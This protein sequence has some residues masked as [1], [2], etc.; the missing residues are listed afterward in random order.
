[1]EHPGRQLRRRVPERLA[2]AFQATA[3][4]ERPPH[5]ARR[6][7]GVPRPTRADVR[8]E[9]RRAPGVALD[10]AVALDRGQVVVVVDR[11]RVHA[12]ERGSHQFAGGALG[13]LAVVH[14]QVAGP[15]RRE[16]HGH[17]A[18]RAPRRRRAVDRVQR[19][20]RRRHAWRGLRQSRQHVELD[21]GE[22]AAVVADARFEDH[23]R[24]IS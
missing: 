5:E 21:V 16:R 9:R 11:R 20:Q 22:L 17:G 2:A 4:D 14:Q 3:V 19:P 1:V 10:P 8:V 6:L 7:R 24:S 12:G 23:G 18:R 15:A 13:Q